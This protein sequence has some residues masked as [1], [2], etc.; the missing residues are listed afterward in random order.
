VLGCEIRT[1]DI[2]A[3]VDLLEWLKNKVD[4]ADEPPGDH[5]VDPEV[6]VDHPAE[7]LHVEDQ[8]VEDARDVGADQVVLKKQTH[9]VGASDHPQIHHQAVSH[10]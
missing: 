8:D 4:Q 5:E 9:E 7:E 6:A 10:E 2:V 1:F 3:E